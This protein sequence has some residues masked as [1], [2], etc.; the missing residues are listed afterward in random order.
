[1]KKQKNEEKLWNDIGPCFRYSKSGRMINKSKYSSIETA[2]IT[3]NKLLNLGVANL[4][5]EYYKCP[6]C[7]CWHYGTK[8]DQ[9]I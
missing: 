4:N 7:K 6:I 5:Y 1:M 9:E 3:Y 8:E 2:K